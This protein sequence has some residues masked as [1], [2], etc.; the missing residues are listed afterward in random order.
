MEIRRK[1]EKHMDMDSAAMLVG[2]I[3]AIPL[4]RLYHKIFTVFYHDVFW[5][6]L[7]EIFGAIVTGYFI[8]KFIFWALG[9]IAAAVW[10]ILEPILGIALI[11]ASIYLLV[12]YIWLLFQMIKKKK[13]G[14]A[15]AGGESAEGASAGEEYTG[16]AGAFWKT[17]SFI[18]GKGITAVLISIIIAMV[19][20]IPL[21][22]MLEGT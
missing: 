15:T 5:G 21:S 20:I 13:G 17:W 2:L 11:I 8:A 18:K 3:L 10:K 9:G 4:W 7:G 14:K 12:M 6:I 1:A 16:V 22:I 19:W